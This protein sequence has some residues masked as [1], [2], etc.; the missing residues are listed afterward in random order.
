MLHRGAVGQRTTDNMYFEK[1]PGPQEMKN[2]R[3]C[4]AQP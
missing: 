4:E 3:E 2:G 1:M